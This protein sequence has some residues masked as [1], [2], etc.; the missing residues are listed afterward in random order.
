MVAFEQRL[1]EQE[2]GGCFDGSLPLLENLCRERLLGDQRYPYT[3]PAA[4]IISEPQRFS[5]FDAQAGPQMM[6][7]V[8]RQGD[9]CSMN[10]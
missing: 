8:A 2:R 5:R 7:E 4:L 9:L 3:I 10:V 1:C 6:A